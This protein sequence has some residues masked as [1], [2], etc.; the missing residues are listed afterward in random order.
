VSSAVKQ[1]LDYRVEHLDSGMRRNDETLKV[2]PQTLLKSPSFYF[3]PF[4][5]FH[6]AELALLLQRACRLTLRG[7]IFVA[8]DTARVKGCFHLGCTIRRLLG[9]VMTCMTGLHRALLRLEGMVTG[10]TFGSTEAGMH[11]M[12]EGYNPELGLEIDNLLFCR[13]DGFFAGRASC[14]TGQC[15]H[16]NG[17]SDDH[18]FPWRKKSGYLKT[19]YPVSRFSLLMD[20]NLPHD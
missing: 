13:D 8:A 11:L 20:I 1:T 14:I 17:K 6:V 3:L 15:K 16:E 10:G 9:M 19:A 4:T 7:R 5:L 18:N 2:H 12:P